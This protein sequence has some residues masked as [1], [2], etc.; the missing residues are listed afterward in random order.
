[1]RLRVKN[2][3]GLW[4]NVPHLLSWA[5]RRG[6]FLGDRVGVAAL[7]GR[8]CLGCRGHVCVDSEQPHSMGLLSTSDATDHP[9]NTTK[10][11]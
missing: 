10:K 7:A 1:M 2:C 3:L 4:S 11:L 9:L 8:G 6:F 5:L